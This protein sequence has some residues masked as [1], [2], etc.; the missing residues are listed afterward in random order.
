MDTTQLLLTIILTFTTVL[1]VV[2]GIQLIFVIREV[3]KI[4]MKVNTIFQSFE[5]L[6]S[7]LDHGMS[8]IVGFAKGIKMILKVIDKTTQRKNEKTD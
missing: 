7:G 3:K 5:N 4:L 1:L 6:S 8:E 2:I